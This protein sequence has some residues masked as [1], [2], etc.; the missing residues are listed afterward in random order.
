M[1]SR[2]QPVVLERP[3]SGVATLQINRPQQRGALDRA[4]L[5]LLLDAF[6]ELAGE[7][8]LAAVVLGSTHPVAFCAG[9]DVGEPLDEA[10]GVARME[11]FAALYAAVEACPAVTICAMT[12][13]TVGAGAEL[14]AACDLRV[15]GDNL[16]LRWVGGLLGVPV[17]PARL[18]PLV[19][20][21]AARHLVLQSPVVTA[22]RALEL[23]LTFEIAP[24][25]GAFTRAVAIATELASR[26]VA[27]LRRVKG[28]FRDFEQTERR[29]LAENALLVDFQRN[30]H[31]LPSGA[32]GR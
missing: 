14:A 22:E 1:L 29:V 9:A 18:A 15:A 26:P 19:G 16:K 32:A 23:G 7:P 28:M 6:D 20:L 11:E 5:R 4:S 2:V 27:N 21:A 30:E 8:G 25:D 17:G 3:T 10:G 24:A 13:N 12:G 31:G